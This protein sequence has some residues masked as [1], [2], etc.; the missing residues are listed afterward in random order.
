MGW[1]GSTAV[2]GGTQECHQQGRQRRQQQGR[3]EHPAVPDHAHRR[4]CTPAAPRTGQHGVAVLAQNLDNGARHLSPAAERQRGQQACNSNRLPRGKAAS[5]ANQRLQPSRVGRHPTH[6]SSFISCRA[7]Q[8]GGGQDQ[9][10]GTLLFLHP[11]APAALHSAHG[12]SGS[13]V[14]LRLPGTAAQPGPPSWPQ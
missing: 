8:A 7:G 1:W 4:R 10:Q 9:H 14:H 11:N 6:S 2:R 12:H 3:A 13:R 5:T